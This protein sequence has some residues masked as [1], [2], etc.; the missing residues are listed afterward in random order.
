MAGHSAITHAP[1]ASMLFIV[2]VSRGIM[3]IPR[4]TSPATPSTVPVLR[5]TPPRPTPRRTDLRTPPMAHILVT[6]GMAPEGLELL[7]KSGHMVDNKKVSADELVRIICG[8]DGLVVRSATQVTEAVIKAGA[9]RLRVV[10][11][12]GVGVDNVDLPH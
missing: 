12:A 8:Y 4:L 1:T 7:K 2:C 11:R 3:G 10:G 5:P 6:D 9:P